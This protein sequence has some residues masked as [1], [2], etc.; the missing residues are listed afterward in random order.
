MGRRKGK[1]PRWAWR[2]AALLLL[3]AI[4]GGAWLWWD[5][6]SWTPPESAYP[7]QGAYLTADNAKA[8]I[9]TLRALGASF[10]Y[11]HAST[12]EADAQPAFAAQFDAARATGMPVGAVHVYD[13]CARADGQSAN[14]VRMVPRDESLL[15]SVIALETLTDGCE[16]RVSD[17]AV[18]SELMILINQIENHEGKPVILKITPEFEDRF[19]LARRIER[20][21]W[22]TRTRIEP[23]Y[24]GRPWLLWSANEALVSE[25]SAQPV[26]WVVARP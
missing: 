22:L 18:E 14:F 5:L 2:I 16:E 1:A 11:L 15:P 10:V 24:A 3:A 7:D 21:I 20:N 12:G 25:A 17:A 4:I 19:G 26:E 9:R 6:R 13:P 23:T 8:N